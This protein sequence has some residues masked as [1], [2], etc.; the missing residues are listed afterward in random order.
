[1]TAAGR[2]LR[3]AYALVGLVS[4]VVFVALVGA[5]VAHWSAAPVLTGSMTPT[6]RSGDLVIT[7]QIDVR[8]LQAGQVAVFVPPGES[9]AYAHRV[10]SVAGDPARPVIRTKGDANPAPDAWQARLATPTVPVVVM[11]VPYAGHLV[12]AMQA[13]RGHSGFVTLL[14]L[15]L[16]VTAIRLALPGR[17]RSRRRTRYI[18]RHAGRPAIS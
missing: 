3:A 2:L 10:V 6:F 4:L 18:P 16:T 14:G 9:T 5:R 13:Q 12:M 8:T 17:N 11:H 7:R 1:V 15:S